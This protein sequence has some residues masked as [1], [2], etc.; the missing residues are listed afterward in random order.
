MRLLSEDG[1]AFRVLNVRTETQ[2]LRF[3]WDSDASR[4]AH[5]INCIL[6]SNNIAAGA[7]KGMITLELDYPAVARVVIPWSALVL[8]R[9]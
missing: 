6:N 9:Q 7:I 3:G 4:S 8:R 5:E 2:G 1:C